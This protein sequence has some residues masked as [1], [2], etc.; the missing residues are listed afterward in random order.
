ML[1]QEEH[2]ADAI[3]AARTRLALIFISYRRADSSGY[4]GRL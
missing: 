2:S 4:A 1:L 3:L